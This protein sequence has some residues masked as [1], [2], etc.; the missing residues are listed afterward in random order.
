MIGLLADPGPGYFSDL[1]GG[2]GVGL[3][4]PVGLGNSTGGDTVGFGGGVGLDFSPGSGTTVGLD[5]GVGLF[6]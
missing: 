3:T 1:F 5:L 4:G 6:A 2:G